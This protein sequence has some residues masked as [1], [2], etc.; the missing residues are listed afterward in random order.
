MLRTPLSIRK[1]FAAAIFGFA[2]VIALAADKPVSK[3]VVMTSYPEEVVAR[4]EAAFEK[5]H[6]GTRV[7]ILWRR[8]GDALS[9]LRKPNQG[10]VD[11]Y[12]TCLLY[13]SPSP[14]DQRGS[15]M[16]SSA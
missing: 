9:Y 8:S 11:V 5:V 15:R 1:L 3:V 12:W 16:P 13:T 10:N 7:E 4:F 14:R 6:P 2:S